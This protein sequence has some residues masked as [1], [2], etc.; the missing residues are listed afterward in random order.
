MT[1]KTF[2]FMYSNEDLTLGCPPSKRIKTTPKVLKACGATSTPSV[3]GHFSKLPKFSDVSE[4][5]S[6]EQE[7]CEK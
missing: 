6:S 3:Q 4:I 7:I 1:R 5:S 2:L